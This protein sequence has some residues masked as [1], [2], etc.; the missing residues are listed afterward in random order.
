M[1]TSVLGDM[2]K[3]I[4]EKREIIL[5]KDELLELQPNTTQ[6]IFFTLTFNFFC[7]VFIFIF[8]IATFEFHR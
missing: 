8:Q 1:C 3:S 6:F 2:A 4:R 5:K 7:F